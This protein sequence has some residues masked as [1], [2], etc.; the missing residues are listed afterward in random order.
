ERPHARAL[1]PDPVRPARLRGLR[2]ALPLARGARGPHEPQRDLRPLPDLRRGLPRPVLRRAPGAARAA[3][4][5]RPL[6]LPARGAARVLRPRDDLPDRRRAGPPAGAVVRHRPARVRR[7]DRRARR[8]PQARALPL[9]DRP[10]RDL[11]AHAAAGV[12]ADERRVPVRPGRLAVR[13]A[14][15]ADEDRHRHLPGLLP[16]RHAPDPRARLAADRRDHAAAAQALRAA[17]GDLGPG[18]ADALRHP[19]HRLVPDVLRRLP[20]AALRR[21]GAAVVPARRARALRRRLVRPLPAAPDDR[22]PRRRLARPVRPRALRAG[23][24]RLLPAGAVAVRPGGRRLLRA[25]LR[26]VRARPARRR[27]DPARAAHGL[28]LR[29]DHERAGPHGRDRPARG[30]PAHRPARLQGGDARPGRLLQAPGRRADERLRPAGLRDRRRRDEAHPP[31]RRHP[32]LRVLRRLV[33]RGEL[34]P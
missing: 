9:H 3:Q 18:D 31:H 17:P 30:E 1:R 29:G 12:R 13:A 7:R 20:G 23:D 26:P 25:R 8:L 32:A 14:R 5:R 10:R 15:G 24:R 16:A 34:H 11:P 28:H 19:G 4:A 6:P 21:H 33:D 22:Q 27:P 2:G